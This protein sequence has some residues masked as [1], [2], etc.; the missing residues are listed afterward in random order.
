[1]YLCR[2]HFTYGVGDTPQKAYQNCVSRTH[3]FS[4]NVPKWESCLFDRIGP[5]TMI[6][7]QVRDVQKVSIVKEIV[8]VDYEAA[9]AKSEA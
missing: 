4:D 5:D 9:K 3:S 7:V 1:M 6:H 8:E 2:S